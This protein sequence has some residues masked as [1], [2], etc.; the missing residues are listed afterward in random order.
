MRRGSSSEAAPAH[1]RMNS[2]LPPH[3]RDEADE[4]TEAGRLFQLSA[5]CRLLNA[6][7][8]GIHLCEVVD[9]L[10]ELSPLIVHEASMEKN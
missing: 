10:N 7:L 3:P 5:R 9:M 1:E 4:S 8:C 2:P 6:G